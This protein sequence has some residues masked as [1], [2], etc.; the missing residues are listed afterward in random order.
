MGQEAPPVPE[1]QP[2]QEAPVVDRQ[3]VADIPIFRGLPDDV[4]SR[5]VEVCRVV[6]LPPEAELMKEGE[7]AHGMFVVREG[8]LEVCKRGRNGHE[9]C[10][11]TLKPGDCVGEMALIDIQPRS[12]SARALTPVTLYVVDQTEIARLCERDLNAYALLVLNIAREISRRLRVADQVLVDMGV[13][14]SDLWTDP[15]VPSKPGAAS[16]GGG[17]TNVRRGQ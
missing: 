9:F 2:V 14:V 16:A 8:E 3:F 6:Q 1:A 11:A 5:I 17:G 12:A 13:A 4:I 15:A 10:L 7:L